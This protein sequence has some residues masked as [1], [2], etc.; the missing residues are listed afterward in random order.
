MR[1]ILFDFQG[2]DSVNGYLPINEENKYHS[3]HL[4][5]IKEKLNSA[6][7][8]I[9]DIFAEESTKKLWGQF[10][11]FKKE[12]SIICKIGNT[13]NVTNAW[14]KCYEIITYYDLINTQECMH[15]DNA[16]FPGSF[17]ISAHHYA[18]TMTNTKYDWVASSLL[19][20]SDDTTTP[21]QDKYQL[22]KRHPDKWL[23][24]DSHNGD[25]LLRSN[26]QWFQNK[27][28]HG[29]DLYTSDLG[30]DVSSDYNNQ[31]SIQCLANMGQIISGLITLKPGGDLVT[32][33]YTFFESITVSVMFALSQMFNEL[34]VCKP[35]SSRLSN[36]ETY[37]VGKGLKTEVTLEHPYVAAMMSRIE[38][39]NN[40]VPLFDANRYP[41]GF[42]KFIN[43]TADAL[44]IPQIDSI[45]TQC[46]LTKEAVSYQENHG[47]KMSRNNTIITK[48][49]RSIQDEITNWYNNN[50]I[51]PMKD[52][53]RLDMLDVYKQYR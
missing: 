46:K 6:K 23:I 25:V 19:E 1:S 22:F 34:Y 47:N 51:Y 32:K 14:I 33:Q 10:D 24:D 38:N 3:K 30:F 53:D 2:K 17:M 29:I 20:A 42:L 50:P 43:D 31:E 45:H 21:L 37:I 8:L 39:K 27:L 9:D 49:Q 5:N 7:N 44:F 12:K 16:A 26:Q 40:I 28:N 4:Y 48:Y 15:F 52:Y 11:P 36:S 18:K 13:Y 41:K 35:Y